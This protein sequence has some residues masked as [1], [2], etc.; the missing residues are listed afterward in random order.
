M[1]ERR[2]LTI[3]D[4]LDI[5]QRWECVIRRVDDHEFAAVLYDMT[6]RSKPEEEATFSLSVVADDERAFVIPGAVFYWSIGYR[7]SAR[8]QRTRAYRLSFAGPHENGD[9]RA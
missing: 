2:G 8:G 7:T 3:V 4:D 9:R 5:V 1:D 6:D